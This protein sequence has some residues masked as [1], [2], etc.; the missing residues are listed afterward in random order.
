MLEQRIEK[1]PEGK[2]HIIR[3]SKGLQYYLRM[4]SIDKSGKYISKK[5]MKKINMYIQ[6][7]YDMSILT[8]LESEKRNLKHFLNG[9]ESDVDKI[10][11]IYSIN[12][13][14]IKESITPIDISDSDYANEWLNEQYKHKEISPDTP[15]FIT[16]R[17]ENVRSKSELTI[18]NALDKHGIPY[19]YECPLLL[20]NEIPIYPDFTILNIKSRREFY[21]EHR[22]MM[23][24]RDYAR[25]AVKRLKDLANEGIVLGDNLIIT[26]E[27]YN[28]PLDTKEIERI[29][30]H[31]L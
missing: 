19:K 30:N 14:E 3:H 7:K 27:T 29:I 15:K 16:N 6:K 18:A 8:I 12:P 9:I 17:G 11:N 20:K 21:W 2:I 31:F 22:G 25:N 23:D 4:D 1:Y 5:D 24:D 10:R 28:S 13:K 26:E